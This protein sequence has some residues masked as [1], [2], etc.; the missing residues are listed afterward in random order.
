MSAVDELA[1]RRVFVAGHAG[2]VGSALVRALRP[3]GAKVLTAPRAELDL[4][5]GAAVQAWMRA[6]R[7]QVVLL[8]AARV[9]GIGANQARPVD[10]L[11]EN[12]LIQTHV[13]EAAFREG[14]ERLVF[15]ASSCAYPRDAAQPMAEEVLLTG[16]PEPTNAAYAVAKAA[17]MH[18]ARSYREQHGAA[19][20]S[21]VA[22]N[23][24]GPQR[25]EDVEA[26]HVI[27]ALL[28]R[29][30]AAAARGAPEV[31][32]WGTGRARREFLHADDL[33]RAV[34]DVAAR[35][36]EE[37]WLNVG[38]GEEVTVAELAGM[39]AGTTGFRGRIVFDASRPDGAPRKLLDSARMRARGWRPL[40]G[41]RRGLAAAHLAPP[42]GGARRRRAA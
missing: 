12:L 34:L 5:D 10:F 3:T 27:P 15:L 36:P 13:M 26:A 42:I 22:C 7:P 35:P 9:G 2:L 23:V 40:I 30:S 11:R 28:Q 25:V 18:L 19:F 33:A 32:V 41:L 21:V 37:D 17:G 20:R 1:G 6:R 31:T 16:A 24:Y 14:V 4:T 29:M 8:A 39:I 38:S